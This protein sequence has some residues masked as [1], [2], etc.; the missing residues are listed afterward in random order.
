MGLL[1]GLDGQ[2][3]ILGMIVFNYTVIWLNI[4]PW[5]SKE[6]LK[7]TK[8]LRSNM[9]IFQRA[10]EK[11]GEGAGIVLN[12]DGDAG[13]YNRGNRSIQHLIENVLPI[14]LALPALF[15]IYPIATFVIFSAFCLARILHQRGYATFGYGKSLVTGHVPGF[16]LHQLTSFIVLGMLTVTYVNMVI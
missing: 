2:W 14:F 3:A 8:N 7:L 13:S 4:Y 15:Y 5:R 9:Y 1:K 12:Q 11:S 16:M 6:P 10:T